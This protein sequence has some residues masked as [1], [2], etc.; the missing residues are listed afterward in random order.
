MYV[1]KCDLIMPA[2]NL[3]KSR[4]RV[5]LLNHIEHNNATISE[6]Y[7]DQAYQGFYSKIYTV[8]QRCTSMLWTYLTLYQVKQLC[9]AKCNTVIYMCLHYVLIVL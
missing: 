3:V 6:V 9:T 2:G 7:P 1:H 4:S 5:L 8:I